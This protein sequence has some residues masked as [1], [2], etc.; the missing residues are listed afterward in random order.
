MHYGPSWGN[1]DCFYDYNKTGDKNVTDCWSTCSRAW[2]DYYMSRHRFW[3][4]NYDNVCLNISG[5]MDCFA[6]GPPAPPSPPPSPPPLPPEVW[7]E[8]P[9]NIAIVSFSTIAFAALLAGAGYIMYRRRKQGKKMIPLPSLPKWMKWRRGAKVG[10]AQANATSP[11]PQ[12]STNPNTKRQT[13]SSGSK[14]PWK[15]KFKL[16]SMG[17]CLASCKS[18]AVVVKNAG[19][20]KKK[21][22]VKKNKVVPKRPGVTVAITSH[23]SRSSCCCCCC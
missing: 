10:V 23:R 5:T 11:K 6:G 13:K 14:R 15:L 21:A 16:P 20:Q 4:L 1:A 9:E 12:R 7:I 3:C 22:K 17:P 18:A 19:V 8:Q 2:Y